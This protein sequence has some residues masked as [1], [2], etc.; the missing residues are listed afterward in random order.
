[1][2]IIL[3]I[4]KKG[5]TE[6]R[7]G[8]FFHPPGKPADT[9][10]GWEEEVFFRRPNLRAQEGGRGERRRRGGGHRGEAPSGTVGGE[11]EG[12]IRNRLAL[13]GFGGGW[14]EGKG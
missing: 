4:C 14:K 8:R 7:R 11:G 5:R 2:P 13:G 1:M 3:Y 9:L 10:G 6:R 12:A